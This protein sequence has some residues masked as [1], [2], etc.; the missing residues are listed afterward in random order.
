[1]TLHQ[2]QTA[3]LNATP[4]LAHIDTPEPVTP[5]FDNLEDAIEAMKADARDI[6]RR[7]AGL[8]VKDG[9]QIEITDAEI[10]AIIASRPGASAD[11]IAKMCR[12]AP[13]TMRSRLSSM[14][15]RG[16]V[17]VQMVKQSGRSIR[18]FYPHPSPPKLTSEGN[19]MRASPIRDRLVAFIRANPGCSTPEIA[20]HTGVSNKLAAAQIAEARKKVSI[21]S[22]GGGGS[23]PARHWLEAQ[24]GA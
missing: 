8:T 21:R 14:T 15:H 13:G 9:A 2:H 17:K 23:T 24:E 1:M 22:V 10:L 16:Q 20:E 7:N 4:R 6:K 19:I 18:T 12:R 5:K 3:R 11:E